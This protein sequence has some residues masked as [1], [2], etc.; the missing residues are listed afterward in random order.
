MRPSSSPSEPQA[1]GLF[2]SVLARGPV[3]DLVGDP[4]WLQAMLDAEAALARAGATA[5]VLP[6]SYAEAI[7]AQCRAD[8]YDVAALGRDAAEV[9][10]PVVP[11]VRALTARVR[12]AAGDDAAGW[13]HFGATSQDV[14]DTATC[15]VVRRALAAI[16]DDLRRAAD[17]A[18]RLAR[19]HRT[20]PMAG[21]TL[22]QHAS[23]TTF[24]LAAATWLAGLDE[25]AAGLGSAA[26]QLPAQL[27][28]ATGTAASLGTR[29]VAVL[30]SFAGHLSL[31][32]PVVPWHT[33]RIPVA[34]VA[35]A[36]GIAAG[37][38]AK[39]AGDVVLLAQ[40]EI[41][42]VS[43]GNPVRGGSSTMPHKRNPVAAVSTLAGARQA[44]GLVATV[45]ASMQQEHQ[46]A[47]GAWH[48]E[49]QP[50]R[51]LLV[52]TGSAAAWLADCLAD[53]RV[54]PAR[55]R[56]GVDLTRGL[57]LAERVATALQPAVGRLAA[58][59]LVEAAARRASDEQ[60]D[61]LDVLLRTPPVRD[62]LGEDELRRLMDPTTYLGSAS[63]FIDRAVDRHT[64]LR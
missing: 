10:N 39:V 51:A 52:A 19:E 54:D 21:R 12:A 36:L 14:L 29:G 5:G 62:H 31:A 58:H 7:A 20:T 44:P 46:R 33:V 3:R 8:R 32:E 34:R 61:L 64:E 1:A 40:T 22:L 49:W 13:V 24:G 23:P 55:M 4:A 63:A 57:V 45:L 42:E 60:R 30:E 9:G 16:E 25:A 43:E 56:A 2:D 27:G 59:E 41:G 26:A 47:A 11:A 48:A 37:A 38:A 50:L 6:V 53:L 15:I 17:S 35:A 28:G 18:A